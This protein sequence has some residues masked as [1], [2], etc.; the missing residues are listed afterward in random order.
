MAAS[1]T[2][3]YEKTS[4]DNKSGAIG[5]LKD[6]AEANSYFDF[7]VI[8]TVFKNIEGKTIYSYIYPNYITDMLNAF[9][10]DS[11]LIYEMVNLSYEEGYQ[12]FQEFLTKNNLKSDT[13][14]EDRFYDSLRYNPLLTSDL[15]QDFLENLKAYILDGS[16]VISM[17][18]SFKEETYLSED[19]GTSFQSLSPRAKILT[20]FQLFAS[21][22]DKL[23]S[24]N[25]IAKVKNQV[26]FVPYIPF[27]NEGK[28]TQ[29][30]MLM[31]KQEMYKNGKLTSTA[32]DMLTRVFNSEIDYVKNFVDSIKNNSN[33]GLLNKVNN[34]KGTEEIVSLI[35]DNNIEEIVKLY[36]NPKSMVNFLET[37]SSLI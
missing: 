16:R 19:D 31:P 2:S 4:D 30:A 7:D 8:P 26:E 18:D 37:L 29:Y 14:L 15:G 9:K 23:G 28:N 1:S 5:K 12:K 32:K 20:Y 11:S 13:Y 21:G 25:T 34:L 35:Q 17:D 36:N 6:I 10:E 3:I 27:Q 33:K 22:N 24:R